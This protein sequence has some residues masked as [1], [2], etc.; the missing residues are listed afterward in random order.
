MTQSFLSSL[1]FAEERRTLNNRYHLWTGHLPDFEKRLALML[2]LVLVSLTNLSLYFLIRVYC[3]DRRS[4]LGT[5]SPV[6]HLIVST[7][8]RPPP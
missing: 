7:A 2:L 5:H 6:G 3:T 8:G 1:P 4:I